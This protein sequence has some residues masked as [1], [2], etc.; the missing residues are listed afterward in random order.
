MHPDPLTRGDAVYRFAQLIPRL[1]WGPL[2]GLR[3][4]GV[5]NVPPTG[6]FLLICNHQ[7][8]LDPILIQ[9]VCPRAVHAMAKSTQFAAPVVGRIMK[10]LLSFPVRRYQADPQAVRHALRKLGR[11]EGVAIYI[12][13]ERT[14]DGALQPPRLG[15][16]RLILKAGVP[17]VPCTIAGSY[18]AWPRWDR[19]IRLLPVTIRFG[20]PLHFPKLD[21]RCER[22]RAVPDTAGRIME[23]L[24][25]QLPHPDEP[26]Q[27]PA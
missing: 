13:G 19:H 3:V 2:A 9:A 15:T 1:V 26:A 7:S 27:S 25:G 18:D 21:H 23:A 4:E 24:A 17:V 8:N 22:E 5:E 20:A 16:V 6:P 14:W 12:E 10:R 11:G